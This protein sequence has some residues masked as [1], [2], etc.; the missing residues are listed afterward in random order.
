MKKEE[1]VETVFNNYVDILISPSSNSVDKKKIRSFVESLVE[2][3]INII[4]VDKPHGVHIMENPPRFHTYT[5]KSYKIDEEHPLEIKDNVGT[6]F[7]YEWFEYPERDLEIIRL[8]Q[9]LRGEV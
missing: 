6:V 8:E 4:A 7:L 2:R 9:V 3:G 1:I 5:I